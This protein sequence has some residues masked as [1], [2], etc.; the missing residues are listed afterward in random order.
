MSEEFRI[1]NRAERR[2]LAKQS[3]FIRQKQQSSFK[4]Q[5]EMNHRAG[6]T[7]AEIHRINTE[8]MLREQEAAVQ[9][10]QEEK[11]QTLVAEGLS[12]EDAVKKLSEKE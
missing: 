7:G 9:K 12:Y 8:R 11:L 4:K 6:E 1:P 3:G 10:K 5:L 2:R